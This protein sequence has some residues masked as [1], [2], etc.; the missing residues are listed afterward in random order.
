MFTPVWL[1]E[2]PVE[3]PF[4]NSQ[5]GV[6]L[7]RNVVERVANTAAIT[8]DLVVDQ[9]GWLWLTV[10]TSA[11]GKRVRNKLMGNYVFGG[12]VSVLAYLSP[13]AAWPPGVPVALLTMPV[14]RL[15]VKP[16]KSMLGFT[17]K[18]G[19]RHTKNY[20]GAVMV[21]WLLQTSIQHWL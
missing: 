18:G 11:Q 17:R 19:I 20:W 5:I 2:E 10:A 13:R 3:R 14:G 16:V 15:L 1:G 6:G 21:T 7:L 4:L 8:S 12:E 9:Q